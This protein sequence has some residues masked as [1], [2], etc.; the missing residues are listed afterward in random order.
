VDFGLRRAH[1]AEAG[2]LA[3]RACYLAGFSGTSNVEAARRF[4]MPMYGT[5]A[6]SFIMAHDD[7]ARAFLEFARAQPDNIVLLIDTYDTEVGARK[8]LAV[9]EELGQ[10]GLRVG[11]VRL[12]SGDL[13]AHAHR[14]RRILDDG[15]HPEIGIFVSSS[16]DEYILE[17]MSRDNAPVDG[18]GIGT[19]MIVSADAPF[20]DC[21]YKLQEYAGVAR[22][23]RSEGKATMPGRRQIYRRHTQ[24]GVIDHDLIGLADV[25]HPGEP[26]LVK[27][28]EKGKRIGAAEPL[29]DIRKRVDDQLSQLPGEFLSL[30]QPVASP[31]VIAEEI[32]SLMSHGT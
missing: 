5:M 27:C 6:H 18:Y 13:A 4:G 20:L 31:I 30:H 32:R 7:E 14:V 24:G 9:A 17:A 26:L 19:Q 1:G 11:A 15:G 25:P 28:M 3:A 23:K 2:L 29:E 21:A 16:L 22:C 8:V 10:Q 12:D